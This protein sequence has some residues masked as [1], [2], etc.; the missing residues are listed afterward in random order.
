MSK[1]KASV[2][3]PAEKKAE[4]RGGRNLLF[5]GIGAVAIALIS[6][7]LSLW[8]YYETGDIYIDRSRPGFLPE[9]TETVADESADQDQGFTL[10]TNGSL[11]EETLQDYLDHLQAEI[12]KLDAVDDTFSSTPLTDES[13]GI[14]D[15]SIGD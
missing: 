7:S 6:T 13:L 15:N 14:P 9:K 1:I 10:D 11:S 4:I 2:E 12:D 8:V 5:L 3:R